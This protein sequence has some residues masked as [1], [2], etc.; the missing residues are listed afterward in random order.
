MCGIVGFITTES[1]KGEQERSKFLKQALVIDTLRGDDSTGVFMV[2]HTPEFDDGTPYW[3]KQLGTGAEFVD[4]K[5]YW[6]H[7]YDVSSYRA[8]VGHNRAATVGGVDVDNAHPFQEGPITLVHNGTLISTQGLPNP[9]AGLPDVSVDSH[10]ICHNLA[11]HPVETVVAKLHGAFAL[12]WQRIKLGIKSIHFPHEGQ[13]LKWLPDTP[14]AA[15]IVKELDLYEDSWAYNSYPGS[16]YGGYGY[17]HYGAA[18]SGYYEDIPWGKGSAHTERDDYIFVG[19]RKK[20]VP[21]ILQEAMLRYD[22]VTEDRLRFTPQSVGLNPQDK[23][24]VYV[25]GVLEGKHKAIL[26]SCHSPV[27]RERT[28]D[29]WCVRV[30]GVKISPEGEPWFIIRLVSTFVNPAILTSDREVTKREGARRAL[31]YDQVPGPNGILVSESEF[32]G[33]VSDGCVM[34]TAPI[35]LRDAYDLVWTSEGPICPNCDDR[36][37]EPRSYQ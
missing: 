15:P 10:A 14:L 37:Y 30:I 4:S 18:D 23:D 36:L 2:G 5:E 13:Y 6:E 32:Y 28:G 1:K 24:R 16:P 19:G 26:Y 12:V 35:S 11:K 9:L 34:C 31:G 7:C 17:P 33:F 25:T 8:A 21:M 22:V 3:Y 29:D 20:P 27:V